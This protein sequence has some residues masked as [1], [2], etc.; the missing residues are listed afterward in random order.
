M[1]QATIAEKK[2][3]FNMDEEVKNDNSSDTDIESLFKLRFKNEIKK[4]LL[5]Q[6]PGEKW[7]DDWEWVDKYVKMHINSMEALRGQSFI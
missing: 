5:T 1:S 3:D 4:I 2:D 7:I 6:Q